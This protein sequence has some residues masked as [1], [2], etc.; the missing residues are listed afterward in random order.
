MNIETNYPPAAS[1]AREESLARA[2]ILL[3]P[4][5]ARAKR[6]VALVTIGIPAIGFV[7]ALYLI[8][9]GRATALDYI[10]FVVFYAVQ[11]FGI[12]IGFHRYL[13]HKSFKTSRF[14]EGVLMITGS[15]ALEGPLLFWV[16][17]HRRHH[18]FADGPGDPHSPNLSGTG[19]TGK[20]KGSGMPTFRGCS[21]TK[22]PR[23]RF[24]HPTYCV[25]AVS[26]ATTGRTRP[27]RC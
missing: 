14:F 11:M 19:F 4:R 13:A 17:T 2:V 26:T 5:S 9:T 8:L 6:V 20:L 1:A 10:L 16:T 7:I 25:I 15:M 24:S 22:S 21:A 18:R 27:G 23:R 12:T 3:N